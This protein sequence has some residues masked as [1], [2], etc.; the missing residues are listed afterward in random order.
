MAHLTVKLLAVAGLARVLKCR[1]N[2]KSSASSEALR[3]SLFTNSSGVYLGG[4]VSLYSL[5]AH[6]ES[7]APAELFQYALLA[8]WLT[9][10]LYRTA[11]V[12]GQAPGS[13]DDKD[14]AT[15][16]GVVLRFLQI[17]TC[18]GVEVT[19]LQLGDT[20]HR[21]DIVKK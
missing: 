11:F 7:R 3:Q 17:V 21:S 6:S 8:V 16:G 20:L 1:R 5:L 13:S 4:F 10:L 12:G 15:V 19:E 14:R 2:P 18:N 9:D